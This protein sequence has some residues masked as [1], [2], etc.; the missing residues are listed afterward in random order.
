LT[1]GRWGVTT[2]SPQ[3]RLRSFGGGRR[4]SV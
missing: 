4:W 2:Y 3:I 1:A